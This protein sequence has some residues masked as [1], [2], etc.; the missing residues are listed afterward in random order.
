LGTVGELAA[1]P[2]LVRVQGGQNVVLDAEDDEDPHE[3]PDT[4]TFLAS[5]EAGNDR[6]GH[7]GALGELLLREQVE[8]APGHDVVAESTQG[9]LGHR[10]RLVPLN[11][12]HAFTIAARIHTVKWFCRIYV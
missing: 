2:A 5:F 10:V 9:I 4:D 7:A 1:E 12:I 11:S 6:P 8:L 3:G